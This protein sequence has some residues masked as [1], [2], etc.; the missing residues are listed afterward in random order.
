MHIHRITIGRQDFYTTPKSTP[1]NSSLKLPNKN[2]Y[3]LINQP[4]TYYLE[5]SLF[6]AGGVWVGWGAFVGI[7][8]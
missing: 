5:L 6:E 3:A 7:C 2:R 1:L 8:S 4:L